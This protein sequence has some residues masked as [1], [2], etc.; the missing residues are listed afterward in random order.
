M[1]TP[2]S[3][4]PPPVP[5]HYI[6]PTSVP[7]LNRCASL[8]NDVSHRS[9]RTSEINSNCK[10]NNNNINTNGLNNNNNNN[11]NHNNINIQNNH[12]S[13]ITSR[14]VSWHP[15][16]NNIPSR[17]TSRFYQENPDVTKKLDKLMKS[18]RINA[19]KSRLQHVHN[20]EPSY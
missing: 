13:I 2:R 9:H 3:A 14:P 8:P 11:N 20:F 18:D 10:D 16:S 19:L 7:Q 15:V 1:E 17:R 6:F 4:T 5:A 12:H